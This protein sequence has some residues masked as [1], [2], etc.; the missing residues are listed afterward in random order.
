VPIEAAVLDLS[1][2]ADIVEVER[3]L[4]DVEPAP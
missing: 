2:R 4:A 1:Q 3:R